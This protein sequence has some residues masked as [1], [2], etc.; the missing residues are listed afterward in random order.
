[1][2]FLLLLMLPG[3]AFAQV[4]TAF[5]MPDRHFGP[6]GIACRDAG[7]WVSSMRSGLIAWVAEDGQADPFAT[8]GQGWSALGMAYDA[9][10]G[11]LWVAAAALPQAEAYDSSMAGQAALFAFDADAGTLLDKI[12]AP[13]G[14][15]LGDVAL[16]PGGDVFASDG[17]SGAVYRLRSGTRTLEALVPP[18]VLRS[19]QGMAASMDG[20][21]LYVADYAMGVFR[22]A[23][24]TG[25]LTLL[26]HDGRQPLTGIDGLVRYGTSLLAVRNAR[27]PFRVLQLYVEGDRLEN[28]IVVL[29]GHPAPDEP[30]LGAVWRG[31][32]VFVAASLWGHLDGAGVLTGEPPVPVLLHIPLR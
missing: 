4:D 1:M 5:V 7:C 16:H 26:R 10:R 12:D 13:P 29:E 9:P 8:V 30:T 11:R 32:Y 28:V 3:I 27:R 2:R 17:L 15:A 23:L 14:S 18:G 24:D 21:L 22:L 6:E 19:P 25:T 31:D 20:R